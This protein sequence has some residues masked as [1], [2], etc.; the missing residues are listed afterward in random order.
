MGEAAGDVLQ[1]PVHHGLR[2]HQHE[3]DGRPGEDLQIS[4]G[5]EEILDVAIWLW[6]VADILFAQAGVVAISPPPPTTATRL[7]TGQSR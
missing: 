1:H 5:R 4:Q 7:A 3:Y 6:L 2:L